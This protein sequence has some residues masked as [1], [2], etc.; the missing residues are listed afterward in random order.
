MA[1]V[2][3]VLELERKLEKEDEGLKTDVEQLKRK[4]Q[5]LDKEKT[6]LE[7]RVVELCVQKKDAETSKEDHGFVMMEAG[8]E[9]ARK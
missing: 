5:K 9:R 8:F 7:A 3:K 4:L 2:Q 6:K 1:D